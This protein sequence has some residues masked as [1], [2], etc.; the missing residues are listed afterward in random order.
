M[1]AVLITKWKLKYYFES[2]PVIVVT[3]FPLGE[4]IRNPNTIGRIAK[5]ALELMGYKISYTSFSHHPQ[6]NSCDTL[7]DYASSRPGHKNQKPIIEIKKGSE[8]E[9]TGI[10]QTKVLFGYYSLETELNF[11][12]RFFVHFVVKIQNI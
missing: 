12:F 7:F 5:W 8:T 9:K 11:G 2:H 3:S 4:A 1:H 10:D 6:G